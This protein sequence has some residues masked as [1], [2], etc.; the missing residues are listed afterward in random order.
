MSVTNINIQSVE[1]WNEQYADDPYAI[2]YAQQLSRG[3][4]EYQSIK[5]ELN[6]IQL[7]WDYFGARIRNQDL[8]QSGGII[9]G[10]PIAASGTLKLRGEELDFG[11]VYVVQSYE[12]ADY[13]IEKETQGLWI[14]LSSDC[15]EQM[16]LTSGQSLVNR[17]CKV[18]LKKL[19]ASCRDATLYSGDWQSQILA[20][21]YP[22]LEPWREA[23]TERQVLSTARRH[24][25]IFK[26]AEEIY[27]SATTASPVDIDKIA[28]TLGVSRRTLFQAFQSSIGMPPASYQ[29]LRQLYTLR[30]LLVAMPASAHSVTELATSSGFNHLGRMYVD[31]HKCFGETPRTTLLGSAD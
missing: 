3:R 23:K 17:A 14:F 19:L 10:F 29:R 21:L 22:L 30:D 1:Q 24:F 25:E 12:D 26:Q 13:L 20:D 16:G 2:S 28:E 11:D 5:V 7:E 8:P 9:V 18:R 15:A 6:G 4:L 27:A 31:Y